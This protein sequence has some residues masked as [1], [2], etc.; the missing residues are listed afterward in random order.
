MS[1]SGFQ[2][3]F[4]LQCFQIMKSW[5]W[6]GFCKLIKLWYDFLSSHHCFVRMCNHDVDSESEESVTYD[7]LI[8]V[9]FLFKLACG[10]TYQ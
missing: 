3:A 2:D 10:R 7:S 6:D 8:E 9:K 5:L 1:C 4:G